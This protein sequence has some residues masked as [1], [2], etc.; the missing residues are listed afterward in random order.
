MQRRSVLKGLA[1]GG[2]ACTGGRIL[3]AL[4]NE[5]PSQAIQVAVGF[6]GGGALDVA[7]RMVTEAL[8]GQG[9]QPMVILNKPGASGTIAAA[10]VAREAANG[11]HLA[12]ATSSNMGIAP[13]LYPDLSYRPAQDFTALGQFAISQNVVYTNPDDDV[14][15]FGA[16][17]ER[18]R[19]QP[20]HYHF[21][22]PGAGTTAHLCFELLKARLDLKATHVPYKGS[23]AALSAVAAGEVMVG[24]DAIGPA[25]GFFKS[26]RLR[27]LAQTGDR[28][29]PGLPDVPTFAE[30]GIRNIPGGTFLGFV[31]PAGLSA[32]IQQ[33]LAGALADVTARPE[34]AKRLL[35]AGMTVSYLDPDAFTAAMQEEAASWGEAVKASNA[36]AF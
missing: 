36:Q 31:A 26:G 19:A 5:Y 3:P 25:L 9:I 18:L 6:P 13:F 4:A 22:S 33:K 14:A 17:V 21:V 30:L 27:P 16:L 23:P 28:R 34:L 35:T 15:D 20:D 12:L 2:L 32:N 29:F 11:Y 1:L 24:V 10:Q 8:A 7:T